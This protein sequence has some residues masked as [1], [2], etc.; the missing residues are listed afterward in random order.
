VPTLQ[1]LKTWVIWS[2]RKASYRWPPRQQALRKSLATKDDFNKSGGENVSHLVRNFYWCA[3]CK[4]VFSRKGVSL[5]HIK[6]VVDPKKGW[7][8]FDEFIRRMFCGIEGFQVICQECHNVKT[9]KENKV[10]KELR[11]RRPV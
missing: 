6:P 8:G 5:D 2:L 4:K 11:K 10:R 3:K 1:D 9:Q 7:Q